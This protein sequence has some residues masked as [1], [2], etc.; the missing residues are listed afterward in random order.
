MIEEWI[1]TG[2]LTFND[3]SKERNELIEDMHLDDGQELTIDCYILKT[4]E[5]R[6][7]VVLVTEEA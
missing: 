4:G 7:G 2:C 6:Y 5:M 3:A 1:K